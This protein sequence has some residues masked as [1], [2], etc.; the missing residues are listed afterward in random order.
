MWRNAVA[1]RPSQRAGRELVLE[2][3]HLHFAQA[4]P[5]EGD[6]PSELA[7]CSQLL[8]DAG[9]IHADPSILLE[10]L[11]GAGNANGRPTKKS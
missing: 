2:R 3:L 1:H 8:P 10:K 6:L 11:Y 9:G 7:P 4:D 5:V